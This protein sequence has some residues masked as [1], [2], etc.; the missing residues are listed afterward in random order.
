M[1]LPEPKIE[2]ARAAF[3]IAAESDPTLDVDREMRA[4]DQ[5]ANEF[6]SRLRPEW[7]NLQKLARL[8]AFVYEEL[9]FRGDERDYYSPSNSLLHEVIRRRRGIPLTLSII[10]L[11][12]GW[13]AG[14]PLEGVGFPGHFLVRLAGEPD[15]LLLDPYTDGRSVHEEECRRMLL[16]VSGGK[17]EYDRALT[18]SVGKR[19]MIVRLLQNLKSAYLRADDD[20]NALA[21]VE[22]LLVLHPGDADETRDE[23]LLL[24]RLHKYGRALAALEAYLAIRA[25]APDRSRIESHVSALR[26]ILASLN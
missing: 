14:M 12:L 4:L 8:R 2:L 9:Q 24:F 5:L 15:D 20:S 16:E 23:G 21:A 19:S 13:R 10:F 1:G 22:R 25:V 11:E 7:N 6:R 3:T 26:A 18:A 17:L